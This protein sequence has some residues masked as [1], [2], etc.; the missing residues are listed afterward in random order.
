[1]L[2][3]LARQGLLPRVD[4]LS[5]VS[6]G[7]YIGAMLARLVQS[8]GWPGTL[9]ALS[10]TRSLLQWWVFHGPG[11]GVDPQ[12]A[13]ARW[14]AAFALA[15]GWLALTGPNADTANTS[16]LHSFYRARLTRA[17]VAVGN[18]ARFDKAMRTAGA[19]GPAQTT[20]ASPA[21]PAS[22]QALAELASVREVLSGDDHEL[23]HHRPEQ[24]GGPLHLIN[25]CVNQTRDDASGLYNADRKGLML[26]ASA[27]GFEV[28][29]HGFTPL[30]PAERPGTVGRWVAMS[31]A[32]AAPGAGSYT[33]SGWALL[34][35]G[36]GMRLGAWLRAPGGDPPVTGSWRWPSRACCWARPWPAFTVGWTRGGTPATAGTSRTP[37]CGR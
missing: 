6:G 26:T 2:R 3:G 30:M 23:M 28:G 21:S 25:T 12:G 19:T 33:S 16:S 36:L 18:P 17:Y 24:A 1:V 20:P 31:G 27:R 29:P 34:L 32:A 4:L 10:D 14:L 15:V 7:G 8:L 35:F 11:T 13:A 5:T 22:P 37:V 9:A